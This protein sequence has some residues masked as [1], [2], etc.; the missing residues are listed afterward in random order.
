MVK[1][2]LAR[3][4]GFAALHTSTTVHMHCYTHAHG[5]CR[6][7]GQAHGTPTLLVQ[8]PW[9]RC[10]RANIKYSRTQRTSAPVSTDHTN[11]QTRPW[12]YIIFVFL[13]RLQC[14]EGM[15]WSLVGVLFTACSHDSCLHTAVLV[16]ISSRPPSA[17]I[18]I[19][20]CVLALDAMHARMRWMRGCSVHASGTAVSYLS[21]HPV[22]SYVSC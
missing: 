22:A 1:V 2:V 16:L 19:P 21:T 3:H 9:V 14:L 4:A 7:P 17:V 8:L 13:S 5:M 10:V 18:C 6:V 11:V 20:V 15:S 12:T